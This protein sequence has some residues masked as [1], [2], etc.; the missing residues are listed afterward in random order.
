MDW[1]SFLLMRHEL[2]L[3]TLILTVLLAEIF[4]DGSRKRMVLPLSVILFAVHTAIGFFPSAQGGLFGDMFVVSRLLTTMKNILNIG[5]LIVLMQSIPWLLKDEN[6]GK[7]SEYVLLMWS[8]LLGMYFLISSGHFLMFFIGIETA[9]IPLAVLAAYDRHNKRSAEAGIKLIMMSALSTGISI[10]GISLIY[11]A[12]GTMYFATIATAI[13]SHPMEVLGLVF[14]LAGMAFKISLVPFHFWAPDVYEGAPANVTSYL[15]VISK[16]AAVFILIV[17]LFTVFHSIVPLWRD[18]L[19]ALAILTMT[20][21]NLFALRQQNLKRFLAFSSIAQAGFI[22]LGVI[23]GNELGMASVL[24]FVL[25]YIFSNLGAFGVIVAISNATG[26]EDM[27]DYNGLYRTN[28]RL[29]LAMMLSLFSLAGI[30]P[31]AGFFGKFFLFAAAAQQG[32]YL[33]VSVAVL[34]TIVSLYYYLLIVKAMFINKNDTPVAPFTTDFYTR[35]G[36]ILCMIGLI[37]AG[38]YSPVFE[39]LRGISIGI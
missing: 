30:P 13:G 11:G 39:Y 25:V 10:Y 26:K 33:L 5:V 8:T 23:A 28:P 21:G 18:A 1:Q 37:V 34:N 2:V 38:I 3:I 15:S 16:G 4:M 24:Y 7:I 12:T 29:S 17:L 6:N 9:T 32:Y 35:A 14:F 36:L 20:T 19:I 22:L 31:V 27:D